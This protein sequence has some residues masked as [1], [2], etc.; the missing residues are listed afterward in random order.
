MKRDL[1]SGTIKEMVQKDIWKPDVGFNIFQHLFTA[2]WQTMMFRQIK[3]L[4]KNW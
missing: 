1:K 2:K 3:D 4:A